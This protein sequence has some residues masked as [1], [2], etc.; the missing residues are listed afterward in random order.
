MMK[1][2]IEVELNTKQV[3]RLVSA[4][5]DLVDILEEGETKYYLTEAGEELAKEK[6][7]DE[8]N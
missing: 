8:G 3:T 4:I 1:I 5:E 2:T 7:V 6:E